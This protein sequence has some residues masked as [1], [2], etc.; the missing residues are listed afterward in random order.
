[1]FR[2]SRKCQPFQ[3][4]ER[5]SFPGHTLIKLHQHLTQTRLLRP[6]LRNRP[7]HVIDTFQ[8]LDAER[9]LYALI[10]KHA[11]AATLGS[12]PERFRISAIHRDAETNCQ[13]SFDGRGV[14][15]HEVRPI[16]INNQ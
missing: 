11:A 7:R 6:H 14:V 5:V 13:I 2:R 9:V 10:S 1:M 16:E 3:I 4:D 8:V 15:R 12:N